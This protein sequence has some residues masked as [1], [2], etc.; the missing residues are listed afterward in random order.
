MRSA[1]EVL[2]KPIV[3]ERTMDLLADN[4]YT[5]KVNKAAN[6]IEIRKAV[7][8]M[9][10]VTVTNVTTMNVKGKVKRMGR[11]EGKTSSWKKAIVTLQAGDKI[12]LYEG[13]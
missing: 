12:E 10:K 11:F 1:R 13:M 2:I 4:K 8:E 6:K 3:T 7:E 5:F 9:F